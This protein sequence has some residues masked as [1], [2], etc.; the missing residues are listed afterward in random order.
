MPEYVEVM[1][2]GGRV[3]FEVDDVN[4]AGPERVTRRAGNVIASLD[5]NLDA[6]LATVR[7]AA[8]K[9]LSNFTALGLD[10][11]EIEFGLSLD[12]QAG[13][14]IAKTGVTGHFKVTLNWTRHANEAS[15][16]GPAQP[17]P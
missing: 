13:A 16:G 10:S 3:L 5:E 8:E 17:S 9:V 14:V 11:V 15:G 6:A 7:P 4:N 12:A 2:D 1:T